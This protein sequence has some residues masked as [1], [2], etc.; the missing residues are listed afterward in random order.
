MVEMGGSGKLAANAGVHS[1]QQSWDFIY[2]ALGF[3]IAIEGTII[4]MFD[5]IKFPCNIILY[6]LLGVITWFLFV[7]NLRFRTKLLAWKSAYED[8]VIY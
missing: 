4:Q 8:K 1:S 5:P 7:K 2:I 3:A 6:L